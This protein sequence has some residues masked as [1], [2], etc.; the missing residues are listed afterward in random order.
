MRGPDGQ[1]DFAA[2]AEVVARR[3]ARAG[4][5]MTAAEY[6]EGFAPT[7]NLVVVDG[8]KGQLSAALEAMRRFETGAVAFEPKALRRHAETFDR[9]V[10]KERIEAYL[11]ACLA[12]ASC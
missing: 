8:G 2:M 11:T 3:F 7:P 1:D 5:D 9:P 4:A 12:R 10:F 6:D